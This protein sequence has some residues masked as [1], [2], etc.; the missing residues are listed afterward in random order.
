MRMRVRNL[1]TGVRAGRDFGSWSGPARGRLRVPLTQRG[2][3]GVVGEI[4]PGLEI[5]H[6]TG[7]FG[8]PSGRALL[9]AKPGRKQLPDGHDQA[10]VGQAPADFGDWWDLVTDGF[11]ALSNSPRATKPRPKI[12]RSTADFEARSDLIHP[13]FPVALRGRAQARRTVHDLALTLVRAVGVRQSGL[14]QCAA[15][16]EVGRGEA[17]SPDT[18]SWAETRC[19][20]RGSLTDRPHSRRPETDPPRRSS[21]QPR[22]RTPG[23]TRGRRR[24]G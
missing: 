12:R 6:A 22:A 1:R 7:G 10:E 20:H 18:M 19:A 3:Q 17:P 4:P 24:A 21:G 13:G 2:C 11:P 15:Q 9:D 8:P 5:R 23:S 14:H 16:S